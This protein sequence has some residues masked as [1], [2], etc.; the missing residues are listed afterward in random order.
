MPLIGIFSVRL[1]SIRRAALLGGYSVLPTLGRCSSRSDISSDRRRRVIRQGGDIK[2]KSP[3]GETFLLKYYLKA[4]NR[5]SLNSH[6]LANR[7]RLYRPQN[8]HE[9]RAASF[10]GAPGRARS[11]DSYGEY[12]CVR[13]GIRDRKQIPRRH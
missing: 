5:S 11:F 7:S 1:I 2:Y 3:L 6:A 8:V 10:R 9:T 4:K 12:L 13:P